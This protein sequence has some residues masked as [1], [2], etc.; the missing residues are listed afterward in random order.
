M[1]TF[2]NNDAGAPIGSDLEARLVAWVLGEASAAEASEL[3]RLVSERPELAELKR[4]LE[5]LH[6]LIG[7]AVGPQA[8]PLRM[9]GPR[10]AG[11][12]RAL[13][14]PA[15]KESSPVAALFASVAGVYRRQRQPLLAAAACLTC[16][17]FLYV[18]YSGSESRTGHA[19]FP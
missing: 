13:G 4:S 1:D 10:R 15:E 11:L 7:E 14:T 9:A 18:V 6:G 2:S 3:E 8:E 17:L 12:L 16:A 5:G 19:V